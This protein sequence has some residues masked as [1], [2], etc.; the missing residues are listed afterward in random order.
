MGRRVNN[1]FPSLPVVTGTI[2]VSRG[3]TGASTIDEAIVNLGGIKLSAIG[4]PG[5]PAKLGPGAAIPSGTPVVGGTGGTTIE[6]PIWLYA[7]VPANYTITNYDSNTVYVISASVGTI[8]RTGDVLTYTPPAV[9]GSGSFAI[10][11]KT[12]TVDVQVFRPVAPSI[13]SPTLGSNTSGV[14]PV[15]TSSAFTMPMGTDTHVSSDWQISTS[16]VFA[17]VVMESLANTVQ[18]TSWNVTGLVY[19]TTYY[20]RVRHRS[21]MNGASDWSAISS[22]TTKVYTIP[23]HEIAKLIASDKADSDAFGVSVSISSDGTRVVVGAIYSDPS[24]IADAGA[25]YI[26]S[27]SGTTWTQEAKISASDKTGYDY[28]GISV[29]IS[30]DGA[31]VV[32][33]APYSDPSGITE[34]GAAY[35]YE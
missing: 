9:V 29:S 8:S 4:A 7:G 19:G 18:L 25:A 32:V 33:G 17:T 23:N 30:S 1:P 3:G 2:P 26:Y 14:G 13:T 21:S 10:N 24:G 15:I 35:I 27:R 22:F 28:F 34:A 31:R 5:T 6:G 16:P 11:G 20:V 12:Y